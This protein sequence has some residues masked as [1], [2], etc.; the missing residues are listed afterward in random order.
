MLILLFRK[1]GV[2]DLVD[3]LFREVSSIDNSNINLLDKSVLKYNILFLCI[4]VFIKL[5]NQSFL[6]SKN[7]LAQWINDRNKNDFILFTVFTTILLKAILH[8][9]SFIVLTLKSSS[10]I[11]KHPLFHLDIHKIAIFSR[12]D[13]PL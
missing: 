13:C 2:L 12:I 8:Q 11:T 5:I 1:S 7:H 10:Q 4:Y 9:Y 6:L 3:S